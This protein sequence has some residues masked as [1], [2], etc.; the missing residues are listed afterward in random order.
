MPT[1]FERSRRVAAG[2]AVGWNGPRW[3]PTSRQHASATSRG[4]RRGSTSA[5]SARGEPIIVLHG[6]P[7]FDHE[8]LLPDMD[9]LAESFRLVYYDQRGRGRSFSGRPADEVDLAGE[10]DDLDAI[11]ESFGFETVAV[12][13][14][15]WGALLAMEYATR[16]P[17]RVS[18]LILMNTAP[19]SHA[20]VL[21]FRDDL[22]RRRT[23]EQSERMIGPALGPALSGRRRRDRPRVLPDPLRLG[24]PAAGPARPRDRATEVGVHQ[25][26]HR[27]RAGDRGPPLRADLGRRGLRPDRST[28]SAAASRPSSSTATATSS[29]ST[30]LGEAADAIRRIALRRAA[31]L[32]SLRLPGAA[33][34]S[35]SRHRRAHGQRTGA[36]T[37]ND[38]PLPSRAAARGGA[39]PPGDD[40]GD[41]HVDAGR[42]T[43]RRGHPACRSPAGLQA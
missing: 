4:A 3:P 12:L 34:P 6:G 27:H 40:A 25:R 26:G 33:R 22:Q 36:S 28:R 2:R 17:H 32:R 19:A 30:S 23:P 1:G 41:H 10:I 35:A 37:A 21:A 38:G 43:S 9:R 29:R 16:R 24:R 42:R 11:R 39:L 8:Y 13:G 15:S 5:R 20:G 31:R 18:H 7:D 14:H